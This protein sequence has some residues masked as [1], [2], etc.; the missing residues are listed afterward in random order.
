MSCACSN[1]LS[2]DGAGR[3]I[4]PVKPLIAMH[5][6]YGHG[7]ADKKCG[8]CARLDRY[9]PGNTKFFKCSLYGA[10]RSA[11]SDWRKKWE[12]CGGF[13]AKDNP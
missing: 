1:C 5:A 7:P 6:R 9:Q 13:L 2:L 12:A 8:E 10:S 4:T 11:A 3:D